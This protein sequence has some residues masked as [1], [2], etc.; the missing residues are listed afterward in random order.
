VIQ[1]PN[2][3]VP[4][5]RKPNSWVFRENGG[6]EV[7]WNLC[8]NQLDVTREIRI[9]TTLRDPL[10]RTLPEGPVSLVWMLAFCLLSDSYRPHMREGAFHW[11]L[12]SIKAQR[13]RAGST[14][15]GSG[16]SI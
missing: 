4:G 6:A 2:R 12:E 16:F 10:A 1:K 11:A 7:V 9:N 5:F 3:K 13:A 8:L 14:P 15:T